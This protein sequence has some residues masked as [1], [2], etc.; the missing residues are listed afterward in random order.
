MNI[1]NSSGAEL[2]NDPLT[3]RHTMSFMLGDTFGIWLGTDWTDESNL[4]TAKV[5]CAIFGKDVSGITDRREG[6]ELTA[7][8][9]EPIGDLPGSDYYACDPG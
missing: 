3:S 2:N 5:H 4:N 7:P 6:R 8:N 1:D 9:G